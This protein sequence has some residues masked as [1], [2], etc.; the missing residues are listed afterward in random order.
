MPLFKKKKDEIEQRRET[1]NQKYA[2]AINLLHLL[3]YD[4]K[5]GEILYSYS[6]PGLKLTSYL[7]NSIL[8]SL[9]MYANMPLEFQEIHLQDD[10][11]LTL[12]DG[13]ITRAALISKN[14]PSIQMQ[15]QTLRF[16]DYFE[17]TF[18]NK[19]PEAIKNIDSVH[20]SRIIDFNFADQFIE[21]CFEKS[22]LFPHL[23][24]RPADNVFLSSEE[25]TL[26]KLAYTINENSG[27]FL[28]GRLLS[29]AQMETKITELPHLTEIVFK[30]REKGALKPIKPRE[31]DKLK[32]EIMREKVRKLKKAK[33]N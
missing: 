9:D 18:K 30:L 12:T 7:T 23:A 4:K 17:Q 33:K 19:I 3:I 24:Q 2:T 26:H 32:D 5:S 6:S 16:I 25:N 15:K 20:V 11:S 8:Q 14:L 28:L 31:A 13:E 21:D 27:P 1:F 22:L 10:L 29:K